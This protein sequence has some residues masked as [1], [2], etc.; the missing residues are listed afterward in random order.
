MMKK[1]LILLITLFMT[2]VMAIGADVSKLY[3]VKNSEP[4]QVEKVLLPV[5]GKTYSN[6]IK[7]ENFYILENGN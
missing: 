5:I 2:P 6:V 1:Y 3:R 4:S 7:G